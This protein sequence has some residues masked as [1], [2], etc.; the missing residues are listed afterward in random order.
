MEV[1]STWSLLK[2]WKDD[3]N[4]SNDK[5]VNREKYLWSQLENVCLEWASVRT[6]LDKIKE[7]FSKSSVGVTT[8]SA[9][10]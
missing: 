6:K 9:Q 7:E 8:K 10:L 1:D 5:I 2:R 4:N 3:I